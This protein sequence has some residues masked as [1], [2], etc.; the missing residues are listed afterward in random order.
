[1][2]GNLESIDFDF[3]WRS[4]TRGRLLLPILLLLDKLLELLDECG[5]RV[6]LLRLE[7]DARIE[8]RE[9]T[10]LSTRGA[11]GCTCTVNLYEFAAV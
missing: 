7:I 2:Q 8:H 3:N 9:Q 6:G 10:D 4:R 11:K 5:E 1:M